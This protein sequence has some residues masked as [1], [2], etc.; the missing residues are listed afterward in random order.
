MKT[1]YIPKGEV[2]HYETLSTE[3]LIVEGTLEVTRGIHAR[4]IDGAGIIHAGT[5]KA[6]SIRIRCLETSLT[7]CRCLIASVVEC[8]EVYASDS[9]VVSCF[10]SAAYVE[11]GRLTS[12]ISEIDEVKAQQIINL[13]TRQRSLLG[14]LLASWWRAL[15]LSLFAYPVRSNVVDAPYRPD[16]SESQPEEAPAEQEAEASEPTERAEPFDEELSRFVNMF[17]LARES[18]YT[19]KLIPGTPEENAPTFDFETGAFSPA[20]AA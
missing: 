4:K 14:T 1:I 12:S 2:V 15:W 7:I 5:V 13:P 3:H 19:L 17:R 10:F 16:M 20:K 9:A 8:P 11:T 18:G 6:E